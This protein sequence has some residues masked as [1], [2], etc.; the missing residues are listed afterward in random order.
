[1]LI[2]VTQFLGLVLVVLAIF[3]TMYSYMPFIL[4]V[5]LTLLISGLA[6][7][8]LNIRLSL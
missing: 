1:M 2:L 5:S 3:A 6:Y 8:I 7:E 4:K